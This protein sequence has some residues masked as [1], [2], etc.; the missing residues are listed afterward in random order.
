M[1]PM[2]GQDMIDK[3]SLLMLSHCVPDAGGGMD[4]ARAWQLLRV[5]ARTHRVALACV[6]DGPVS[7]AQWRAIHELAHPMQIATPPIIHRLQEIGRRLIHGRS[8]E[9]GRPCAS[10]IRPILTEWGDLSFRAVL[11]THPIF[12]G[13]LQQIQSPLRV[14]DLSAHD[15]PSLKTLNHRASVLRQ[16]RIQLRRLTHRRDRRQDDVL[17]LK[18]GSSSQ[19]WWAM[20]IRTILLPDAIDLSRFPLESESDDHRIATF[21]PPEPRLVFHADW[22]R[23]PA[24]LWLQ[25]FVNEVWPTVQKAIPHA[26]FEHTRPGGASDPIATIRNAA[27][28]VCPVP[29]PEQA[30]LP[31]LQAMATQRA[32]IASQHTDFALGVRHGE[33]MLTANSDV[34]W[35]RQC[36]HILKSA[37]MRLR[38]SRRARVFVERRYPVDRTGY[39]LTQTL[40]SSPQRSSSIVARAA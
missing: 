8:G 4:R 14:C 5:S 18:H 3:P 25:W 13:L 37:G 33:H 20:P 29:D 1:T 39:E 30:R 32:V 31:I 15:H 27:A 23:R 6:M 2:S 22:S 24:H 9:W 35:G 7:L 34:D 36:I 17:I 19:P 40:Q 21:V 38:L 28:V 16:N 10:S 12:W 11:A 26:H